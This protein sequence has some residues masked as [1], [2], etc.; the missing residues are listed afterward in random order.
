MRDRAAADGETL[1]S[2]LRTGC[3]FKAVGDSALSIELGSDIDEA[4]NQRVMAL[5]RAVLALGYPVLETVPTYRALLVHYDA[6]AISYGDLV[7]R[8]TPLLDV[9]DPRQT[10]S[11]L[12][13]IPVVYGGQFGID[14]ETLAARH[15]ITPD[16][17]VRAHTAPTYRVYM[18]GFLPGFAY[19]GGLDLRLATPR[20]DTPRKRTPA[21]SISIGGPQAAIASI[22]APSGWHLI[23]RTPV[24][25]FMPTRDP[26]CIFSPGDRI[27]FRAMTEAHWPALAIEAQL[28][29]LVAQRLS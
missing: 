15:G 18:L 11:P 14:L 19:L 17:V 23:G 16:E 22:E 10:D 3:A 12:W 1:Q 28:G 25:A 6:V 9:A 27:R 7:R 29:A 26:V 4:I 20:L 8:L 13:E 21:G 24:R 5:D 2:D